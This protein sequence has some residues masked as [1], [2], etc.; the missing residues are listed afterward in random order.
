MLYSVCPTC[1]F[2]LADKQLDYEEGLEKI[3]G[4]IKLSNEEKVEKRK[5]LISKIGVVRYC[6][7]MRLLSF[8][9]LEKLIVKDE[10]LH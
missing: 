5:T 1:G 9:P 4:D 8:I 7:K 6:C 10:S 2:L 3:M